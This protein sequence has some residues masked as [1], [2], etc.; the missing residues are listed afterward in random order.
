LFYSRGKN[1]GYVEFGKNTQIA[2]LSGFY[3]AMNIRTINKLCIFTLSLLAFHAYGQSAKSNIPAVEI[4]GIL[5]DQHEMTIGEVKRFASATGFQSAAEKAGGGT[6]YELGFVKKS[7]WTWRTP[8]GVPASDNEP[9]V[10]LNAFEAQSIC[11]YFGK[12]LP[13]DK[14]WVEAAH[15]EQRQSPPTGFQKGQRYP[16]PNGSSPKGSHC[17]SSACGNYKGLA[18]AGSLTRGDGHVTAGTTQPGVN[19]LLDM[20]GNVWEWTS[21][22]SGGQRITRGASWWY[23]PDQQLESNVATKPEE[24]VVVYIGLRCVRDQ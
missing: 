16:Y 19:G 21:T 1:A 6:S 8:Y 11:Q 5:W 13:S 10:H 17:L 22:R 23:G 15:L 3:T 24:T 20:G 4:K 18:P 9:A 7:G 12:R 14:E 2:I